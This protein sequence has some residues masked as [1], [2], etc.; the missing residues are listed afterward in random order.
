MV[1]VFLVCWIDIIC[2]VIIMIVN[3]SHFPFWVDD[4]RIMLHLWQ[5]PDKSSYVEVFNQVYNW[6]V[7][8]VE[9]LC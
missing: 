9:R 8:S 3:R 6:A 4:Y 1:E 5:M 7:L 2:G